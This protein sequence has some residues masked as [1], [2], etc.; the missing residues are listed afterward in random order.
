MWILFMLRTHKVTYV[1]K[2]EE[3]ATLY[4]YAVKFNNLAFYSEMKRIED[5]VVLDCRKFQQL[6]FLV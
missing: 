2:E 1:Q 5:L 6:W 4:V 3:T